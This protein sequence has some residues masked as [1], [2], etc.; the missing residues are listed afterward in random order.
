MKI[1]AIVLNYRNVARTETCL[2]SLVGQGLDTVLVEDNSADQ[3]FSDQLAVMLEQQTGLV[4]Y[5]LSLFNP[6]SNLGFARGVNRAINDATALHCDAFLLINNDAIAQP[7]MLIR[8]IAALADTGA[9]MV[10]PT[11][12]DA[13]GVPQSM[14]WYQRF[15]GLLTVRPLPG[16][17]PYLSG[18]CLLVRREM[19]EGGKLFDED[20]FMYGEDTLLGWRLARAG[21]VLRRVNDAVVCHTSGGSSRQ[22]QLFYEYHTARAHVLL[23]LKTWHSPL[24]IPLL[25]VSKSIGLAFR[26]L[27]RS[28]RCGNGVPLLAFILAWFPM[29]IRVP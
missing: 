3:R 15:F 29:K 8:L 11:V 6:G 19:L 18:C 5:R 27:R 23:S 7:G 13:A 12:V 25:L 9:L 4:D 20:F 10:A 2:R 28:A 14:L 24:E 16:S 22:G 26:A 21:E 17:F 1:C